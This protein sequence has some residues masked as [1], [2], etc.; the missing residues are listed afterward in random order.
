LEP[1][2]YK[3][4]R[5]SAFRRTFRS[6]S[7]GLVVI[8]WFLTVVAAGGVLA[9]LFAVGAGAASAVPDPDDPHTVCGV[10]W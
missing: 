10:C 5:F 9:G 1:T 4:R 7:K 6:I 8:K 2:I 3:L